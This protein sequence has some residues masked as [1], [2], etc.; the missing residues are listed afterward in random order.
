MQVFLVVLLL[1]AASLLEA[2]AGQHDGWAMTAPATS[3][4]PASTNVQGFYV[5]R[6]PARYDSPQQPAPSEPVT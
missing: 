5:L 4:A 1:L 6:R 3:G 2:R